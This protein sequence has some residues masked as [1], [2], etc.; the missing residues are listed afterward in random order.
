[1][2][3]VGKLSVVT[4]Y[5]ALAFVGAIVLGAL[6]ATIAAVR[7]HRPGSSFCQV[8]GELPPIGKALLPPRH[9][10]GENRS[11]H[12]ARAR[13]RRDPRAPSG[14]RASLREGSDA[15]PD[16]GCAIAHRRISRFRVRLRE[17]PR[18][19]FTIGRLTVRPRRGNKA[20]GIQPTGP[21]IAPP[22]VVGFIRT[23]TSPVPVT[24]RFPLAVGCLGWLPAREPGQARRDAIDPARGSHAG[25]GRC[26]V[27]IDQ[28]G[29]SA[30]GPAARTGFAGAGRR[31]SADRQ[32]RDPDRQRHRHP[33]RRLLRR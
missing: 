27:R 5:L 25:D 28:G 21:S 29:A 22:A 2:T 19:N 8:R 33:E 16:L 30:T 20:A 11:L 23:G 17:L 3:F 4:A 13:R 31:R 9:C 12:G 14:L 15:G 1:M 6:A 18:M 10:D 24:S 7:L 32:C 26:E